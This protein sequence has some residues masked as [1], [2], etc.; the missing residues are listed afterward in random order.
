LI[1]LTN[2]MDFFIFLFLLFSF[3]RPFTDALVKIPEPGVVRRFAVELVI[4]VGGFGF[5]L[6]GIAVQVLVERLFQRG[7]QLFQRSL[8]LYLFC[9]RGGFLRQRLC[10]IAQYFGLCL[11]DIKREFQY[12]LLGDDFLAEQYMLGY[13]LRRDVFFPGYCASAGKPA[14]NAP[15]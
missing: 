8:K 12:V 4:P 11:G 3:A 10:P 5:G 15:G 1:R 13:P 6:G 2:F 7:V 9:L 14:W